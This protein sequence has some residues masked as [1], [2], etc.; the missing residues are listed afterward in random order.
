MKSIFSVVGL[1]VVFGLIL[2]LIA[3][4]RSVD[5]TS[6]GYD[7][8]FPDWSG[9]TIDFSSMYQTDH[10]LYQRGYVVD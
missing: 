3:D 1:F 4:I 2:G 7:Y 6:G 8:P 9:E 5:K 10:G